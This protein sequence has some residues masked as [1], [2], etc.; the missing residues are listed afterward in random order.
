MPNVVKGSK[1]EKMVVVPYRP[2]NRF[3][4]ASAISLLAIF[5]AAGGYFLGNYAMLRSD[6]T[7][8]SNLQR[9][10]SELNTLQQENTDLRRQVA[11]LDTSSVMDQRA[12]EEVQTTILGLRARVAQLEQ[13]IVFYRQV[14]SEE[15]E[16]TGLTIG[17]FDISTTE[18]SG[19]FRYKLV[20]RQQDADGDTFLT[21]H[22]NVNLVGKQDGAQVILPL[23]EVSENVDQLDIRLRF[24]FFQSIEGELSLPEGFEPERIQIAAVAT[25][26]VAKS[27]DQNF[28]WVVEGE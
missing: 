5:S 15:T 20:L 16:A 28:S 21:G 6:Q 23:R 11:I 17:Q 13:D 25:E 27:I 14:V 8:Q 4:V 10:T 9:L 19:K 12:T 7:A 18:T 26:P 1:Q 24:K 2:K 3:L 22:V